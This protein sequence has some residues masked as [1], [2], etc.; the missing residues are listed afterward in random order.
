MLSSMNSACFLL[1]VIEDPDSDLVI[2]ADY[3][4]TFKL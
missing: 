1:A 4:I 2:L 3:H